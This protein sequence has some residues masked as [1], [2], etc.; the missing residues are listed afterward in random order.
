MIHT[1]DNRVRI[2]YPLNIQ[3][4][5]IQEIIYTLKGMDLSNKILE[6]DT[7]DIAI[8]LV[9]YFKELITSDDNI[10]IKVTPK[11]YNMLTTNFKEIF[12][13]KRLK[14]KDE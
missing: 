5:Q 6:L 4:E 8:S 11:V 12:D 1:V 13:S 10:E 3:E 7:D 14:V 9:F 2:I